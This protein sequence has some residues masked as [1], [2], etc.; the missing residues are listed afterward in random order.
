MCASATS[1]ETGSKA[2]EPLGPVRISGSR[3]RSALYV[4]SRKWLTFA[5]SPPRVKG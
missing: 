3:S 2:P 4:R 1:H 5:H